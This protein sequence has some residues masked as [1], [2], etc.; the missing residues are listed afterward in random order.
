MTETNLELA[1]LDSIADLVE[2]LVEHR[3]RTHDE[4]G[5]ARRT[6]LGRIV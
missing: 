1:A 6:G 3:Q 2:P 5:L 4:G